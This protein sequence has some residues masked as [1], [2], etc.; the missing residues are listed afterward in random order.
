MLHKHLCSNYCY[1]G[2]DGYQQEQMN[3]IIMVPP[4]MIQEKASI[5]GGKR[6]QELIMLHSKHI[7]FKRNQ[8]VSL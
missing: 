4:T 7:E 6:M 5:E 2:D 3:I 1:Y 8:Y